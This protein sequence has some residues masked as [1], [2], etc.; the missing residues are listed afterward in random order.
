[1][2][3]NLFSNNL[4]LLSAMLAPCMRD[5]F[6]SNKKVIREFLNG[7]SGLVDKFSELEE[8][9]PR[10]VDPDGL[11]EILTLKGWEEADK[12]VILSSYLLAYSEATKQISYEQA[13]ET[14]FRAYL[15]YV[16]KGS[17]VDAIDKV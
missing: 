15:N 14:L 10:N 11:G 12:K 4:T 9:M 6:D 3:Q 17:S 8:S 16:Y 13:R 1:M 2:T 5:I 7:S